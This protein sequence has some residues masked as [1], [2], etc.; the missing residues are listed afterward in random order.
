MINLIDNSRAVTGEVQVAVW[1]AKTGKLLH[2][3]SEHNLVVN[4]GKKNIAQLLG[5]S[6][7]GK[8]ISKISVGTSNTTPAVT[9]TAIT[10]SFVKA[11][12]A[13]TYPTDNSVA[14][15]WSLGADD[16][17]GMSIIEF[18]LLNDSNILC[19]RKVRS[20]AIEKNEN[21]IVTGYWKITVN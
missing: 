1:D 11:I 4:L 12:D 7:T 17:N 19:A 15:T 14:Y 20:E 8:K 9:D 10:N 6:A 3:F 5:G 13:V 16:A 21:M 18:G 2:R